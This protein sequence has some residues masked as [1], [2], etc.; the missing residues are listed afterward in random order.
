MKKFPKIDRGVPIP[1]VI[2]SWVDYLQS[3][4]P[5]QSFLLPARKEVAKVIVNA[6]RAKVAITTRKVKRGRIGGHAFRVW[7]V[8]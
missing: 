5:G 1:P 2:N 7:R 4:E 8:K 3:L 6:Q